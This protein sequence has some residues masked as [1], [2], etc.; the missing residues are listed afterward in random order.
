M[1]PLVR[2][3]FSCTLALL[4]LI[5]FHRAALSWGF[6]AHKEVNR[7]A[8][9]SL[10]SPLFEFFSA[11][12]EYLVEHSIA[13]DER[14]STDDEEGFYHYLD[15]DHYGKYPFA[16]L[17]WDYS[18][19]AMKYGVDS[20]KK[21][22]LIPWRIL[23]TTEKLTD[24]MKRRDKKDILFLAA[25]LGHYIADAHGPLH[26]TANYDGQ[27]SGQFGIHERFE[28]RLP[29]IYGTNYRFAR[30]S[31]RYVK[32]PLARAF[33]IILTSYKTVDFVL[34][35]E[36]KAKEDLGDKGAYRILLKNGK[37][38]YQYS[39]EYYKRF[40]EH[41]KGLIEERMREAISAVAD[42]WFTAWVNAGR[43]GLPR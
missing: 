35:A 5:S 16:E 9:E 10:P 12:A 30:D 2:L 19:A 24:A 22:G 3:L 43:P 8:V 29:E 1:R 7:L 17:P 36:M 27:L 31:A 38:E 23:E 15:I 21:N 33:D 42:F 39:D 26:T 13:S 11:N 41:L 14:K 6:W 40:N 4:L 28:S 32:T 37:K 18:A 25:D 34:R 20:L